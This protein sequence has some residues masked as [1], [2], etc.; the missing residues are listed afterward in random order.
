M[1]LKMFYSVAGLGLNI[2]SYRKKE[3]FLSR[4]FF[5]FYLFEPLIFFLYTVK[6]YFI[7]LRIK[8]T[9]LNT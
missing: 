3:N 5:L 8:I 6:E 4:K 9:Q 7:Y 1:Q 2:I